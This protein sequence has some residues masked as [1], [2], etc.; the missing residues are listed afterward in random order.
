MPVTPPPQLPD[1]GP[2]AV[3]ASTGPPTPAATPARP[4]PPSQT[5]PA[6]MLPPATTVPMA[7]DRPVPFTY[8]GADEGHVDGAPIFHPTMAEFAD[9]ETY[10]A[11]IDR[12]YGRDYGIVKVVPPAEWIA[13]LPDIRPQL[14]KAKP[15]KPIA[16]HFVGTRG[17]FRQVNVEPR[18]RYSVANLARASLL[19]GMRPPYLDKE[20]IW[21]PSLVEPPAATR[22]TAD[23]DPANGANSAAE[24]AHLPP[25]ATLPARATRKSAAAAPATATASVPARPRAAK[26]S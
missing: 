1:A 11:K 2:D 25:P 12:Y 24:P 26:F 8:W 7:D 23:A 17:V 22:T 18:R 15:V 16:Q 4:A 13:A 19:P 9:F 21:D 3:F 20:P 10:A 14:A 5:T 6:T